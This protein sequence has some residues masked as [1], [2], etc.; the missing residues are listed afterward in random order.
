MKLYLYIIFISIFSTSAFA[1]LNLN[2][3]GGVGLGTISG[4]LPSQTSFGSK[5]FIEAEPFVEPFNSLQLSFVF[6]QKLEKILP[7]NRINRYYP[8]VKSFSLTANGKQLLSENFFVGEGFGFL[9]LNDRTYSDVN[10]WNYGLAINLFVG[11][12]VNTKIDLTF[13]LDYGLTLNNTNVS[14]VLFMLNIK[15]SL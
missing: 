15:Y 4:N 1:Q 9:L 8:F 3:G 13:N 12:K 5:I 11:V 14:L 10:T 7:Q 6:A 2:I